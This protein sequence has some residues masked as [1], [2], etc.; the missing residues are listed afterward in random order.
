MPKRGQPLTPEQIDLGKE[1]QLR[2]GW[3]WDRIAV[4]LDS[5]YHYVRRSLAPIHLSASLKRTSSRCLERN[6]TVPVPP[7][8]QGRGR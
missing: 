6:S 3:S 5:T 4:E 2:H 7:V 8:Y 1:M